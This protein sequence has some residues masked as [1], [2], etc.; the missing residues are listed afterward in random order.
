MEGREMVLWLDLAQRL[1]ES[2]EVWAA[3]HSTEKAH[4][5]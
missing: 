5:L 4:L 2:S 1:G 3:L